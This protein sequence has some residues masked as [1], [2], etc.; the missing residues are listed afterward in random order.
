MKISSHARNRPGVSLI[1]VL[2]VV[3]ILA[4]LIGLILSAIQKVREHSVRLQSMNNIRQI[5]L[6]VHG[7]ADQ[8]MGRVTNLAKAEGPKLAV[9]KDQSLFWLILPWTHQTPQ[10]PKPGSDSEAI[11]NFFRPYVKIY[12]SPGDPTVN[13]P[14]VQ[15]WIDQL[16]PVSYTFNMHAVNNQ[17]NLPFSFPD[18]TS[19]T[20]MACENYFIKWDTQYH[21][22]IRIFSYTRVALPSIPGE[23]YG[24]RRATFADLSWRDVV[25]VRDPATGTTR[26]SASGKTFQVKPTLE[27]HDMYLPATPFDAGLPVAMFDGSVRVLSPSISEH[28]FWS[29]VT[30]NGGEVIGDF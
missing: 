9:Y 25:P 2:V 21:G 14:E 22:A 29:L 24:E 3:F 15:S 16:A 18:G 7:L 10:V 8:R 20:I 23:Y 5:S 13:I 17:I 27:Q 19:S 30:P 4:I 6:G 11:R 28:I 26:A 1:E 12:I